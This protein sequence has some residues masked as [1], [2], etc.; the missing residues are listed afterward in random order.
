M[1]SGQVALQNE[2]FAAL[3]EDE[4]N[5]SKYRKAHTNYNK[6][7]TKGK[8]KSARTLTALVLRVGH[9]CFLHCLGS[10]HSVLLLDNC[11]G[12]GGDGG[13]GDHLQRLHHAD[14][15]QLLGDRQRCLSLLLNTEKI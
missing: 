6:I 1:H 7:N 13:L 4:G 5:S 8:N 14:I 3:C 12:G 15:T 2:N 9:E 11:G 10:H